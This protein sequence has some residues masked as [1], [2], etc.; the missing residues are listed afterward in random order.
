MEVLILLA[1]AG[2]Y[3]GVFLIAVG[4][5]WWVSIYDKKVFRDSKYDKE[6]FE[7]KQ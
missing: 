5:L 6:R 4:F 7:Q 1:K 2:A 3:F